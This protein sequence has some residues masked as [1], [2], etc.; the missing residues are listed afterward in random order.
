LRVLEIGACLNRG[1]GSGLGRR[2]PCLIER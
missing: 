1:L 2:R